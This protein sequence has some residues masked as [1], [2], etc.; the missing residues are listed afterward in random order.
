MPTVIDEEALIEAVQRVDF[1]ENKSALQ[2]NSLLSSTGAAVTLPQVKKACSKATKRAAKH[3]TVAPSATADPY[4][5]LVAKAMH[6]RSQSDLRG[7]AKTL[8]KAIELEPAR[9]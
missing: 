2:V 8:R 7:A 5:A 6:E 1:W 3:Q 9:P 4:D